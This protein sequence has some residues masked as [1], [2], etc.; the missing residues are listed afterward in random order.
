MSLFVLCGASFDDKTDLRY[1]VS[2]KT[3]II[4]P[5][6]TLA[7]MTIMLMSYTAKD[8][9]FE[10]EDFSVFREI[11]LKRMYCTKALKTASYILV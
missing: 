5:T 7:T 8:Q 4:T 3:A 1:K 11:Q 9:S 6:T 2:A 10:H